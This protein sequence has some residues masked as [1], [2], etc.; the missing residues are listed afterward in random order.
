MESF[1]VQFASSEIEGITI[2]ASE[3]KARNLLE[4][5]HATAGIKESSNIRGRLFKRYAHQFLTLPSQ[6][7]KCKVVGNKEYASMSLPNH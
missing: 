3:K 6:K 2:T 5:I 1:E 4:F 7:F